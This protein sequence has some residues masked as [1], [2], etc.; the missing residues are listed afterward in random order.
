METIHGLGA[1]EASI[2]GTGVTFTILAAIA[3]GLR[4]TSKRITDAPFGLDDWLLLAGLLT[5]LCR[6]SIRDGLAKWHTVPA[7]AGVRNHLSNEIM[8][9][10]RIR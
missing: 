2:V 3:V 9:K 1:N 7:L 8:I 10:L 5:G 6:T 4:F